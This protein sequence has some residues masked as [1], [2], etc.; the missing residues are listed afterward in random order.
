MNNSVV[1]NNGA[2]GVTAT[3]GGDDGANATALVSGTAAITMTA[4]GDVTVGGI[5]GGSLAASSSGG[6]VSVNGVID[7]STG[8]VDLTAATDVNVNAPV[9]NLRSGRRSTRRPARTSTSTRRSTGARPA[10]RR[11][12]EPRA[13]AGNNLNVNAAIVTKTARSPRC[14]QRHGD[15][16]MPTP[17]SL[18]G[19]GAIAL[20]ALGNVTTGT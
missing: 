12:G 8:R 13:T 6:S 11:R 4:G 1:T 19:S 5:S 17:G 10:R 16:S 15:A 14:G 9:L 18:P 3:T 2:I 7:G 20:D